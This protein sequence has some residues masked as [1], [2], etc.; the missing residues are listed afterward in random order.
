M[1]SQ[2]EALN[3]LLYARCAELY[4]A[5]RLPACRLR[6]RQGT[7][8]KPFDVY[9]SFRLRWVALTPEE[10][11]R[12]HFVAFMTDVLGFS[13]NRIANEVSLKLNAMS[14]RADTVVYDD[15]LRP[16]LIVEYKAPSVRLTGAVLE[17]ALRY[18]LVFQAP[19]VMVTNGND[20]FSV[21]RGA[22]RRGVLT[23]AEIKD[24]LAGG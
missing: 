1:L 22:V 6:L 24:I 2:T 17:Q 14:R 4:G 8:D 3:D 19:A 12:Q 15:M 11:V 9:D 5:L 20:V 23:A 13:A 21:L 16:M 10:W 18:N 7:T